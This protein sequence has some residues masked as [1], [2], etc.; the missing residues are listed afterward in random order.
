MATRAR[1]RLIAPSSD[2]RQ[3]DGIDDVPDPGDEVRYAISLVR[4]GEHRFYTLTIPSN[5]LA[6]CSFATT[7]DEDA[8]AGFQRVLDPKRAQEIADYID[9]GGSIPSSVVLSAQPECNFRSVD[10]SKT[11]AF[12]FGSHAFL[13]I[14][15][16]HRVFGFSRAKTAIRVPVVIY[17][18]LT[19]EQEARL[20]IDINTK[21][22]PVPKELLLAIKSLARNETDIEALL[23][24]MFDLFHA[25][26]KSALLGWTSSTKKAASK[27]DRVTFN[28][29]LRPHLP[30]FDG[31]DAPYIY[32][33][34]NAYFQAV[35]SGLMGKQV[36]SAITKKTTFRAFCDIFPEVVQRV[37]DRYR[38]KYV[39]DNFYQVIN[40]V[41]TLASTN[42]SNPKA[43]ITTLS[44]DLKK[45]L[46]SGL[47]L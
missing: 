20:F 8:N 31:K 17:D 5:V 9:A 11:A 23:G 29:G 7:R 36:A 47:S 35:M 25:D 24:Q 46:R 30:L 18:N 4:Q 34:W 19:K 21:Q 41:F 16:Q 38:S 14:D 45:K 12:K 32:G 15:G 6:G 26:A 33:I 37:Q 2:R 13:I 40:P 42:F 22:K 44:L 10:R 39:A 28:A 3:G 43:S 27:I 1:V